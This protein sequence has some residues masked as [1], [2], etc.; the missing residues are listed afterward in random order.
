MKFRGMK[1]HKYTVANVTT[2]T[3]SGPK[4]IGMRSVPITITTADNKMQSSATVAVKL[5]RPVFVPAARLTAALNGEFAGTVA[6]AENSATVMVTMPAEYRGRPVEFIAAIDG[7][8]VLTDR[9]AAVVLNER[10]G[11]VVIGSTV[12]IAP[13]AVLHGNLTVQV[14]TDY[15]VSQPGPLSGG[16]TAITP[17]VGVEVTE[18]QARHVSLKEGAKVEELVKALMSI[19]STPRDIIAIMQSIAAAGALDARLE[20][21]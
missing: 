16:R 1:A 21:I 5:R 11:T 14:V 12:R 9:V 7:L 17:Q 13:V 4:S 2:C 10:T 15:A 3:R 6:K 18:E 20:V 19:G 8:D